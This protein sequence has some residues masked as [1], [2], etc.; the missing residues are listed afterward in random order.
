[1]DSQI[2]RHRANEKWT[3]TYNKKWT[4]GRSIDV[5]ISIDA[6]LKYLVP[7]PIVIAHSGLGKSLKFCV[8]SIGSISGRRVERLL[9]CDLCY[10]IVLI[11]ITLFLFLLIMS[12]NLE[13]ILIL[14]FNLSIRFYT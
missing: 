5:W 7:I 9:K 6:T 14:Q 2:F 12:V 13:L 1:M 4:V 10:V 8:I 11:I 3:L